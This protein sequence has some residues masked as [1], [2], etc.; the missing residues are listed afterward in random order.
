VPLFDIDDP[1]T[2]EFLK[3]SVYY[4]YLEGVGKEILGRCLLE[5]I[6]RHALHISNSG[7]LVG[8]FNEHLRDCVYL[9][10]DEAFLAG[11]KKRR[12]VEAADH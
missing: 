7:Q 3:P 2:R 11:N 1:K 8:R 4:N 6:G 10:A 9:F 5:I 12:R